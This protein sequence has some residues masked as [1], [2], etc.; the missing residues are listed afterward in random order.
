MVY[1]SQGR[2]S[3][4]QCHSL[5][6]Q[7][8]AIIYCD[9]HC[10]RL[11]LTDIHTSSVKITVYC[12][13]YSQYICLCLLLRN[14]FFRSSLMTWYNKPIIF[15][16]GRLHSQF[17]KVKLLIGSR[18]VFLIVLTQITMSA[19]FHAFCTAHHCFKDRQC[20]NY[21]FIDIPLQ[22]FTISIFFFL[23]TGPV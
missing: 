5:S 8:N 19:L 23:H 9:C 1:L 12:R 22:T 3:V 11:L 20:C 2:V 15:E 14:V 4:L 10:I 13:I 16:F 21:L 17:F 6:E 7:R 18:E